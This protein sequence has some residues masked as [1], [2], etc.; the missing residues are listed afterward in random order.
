MKRLAC[1]LVTVGPHMKYFL[2]TL[3]MILGAACTTLAADVDAPAPD[4]ATLKALL[5]QQQQQI[6]QLRQT[7]QEQSRM[8]DALATRGSQPSGE[9]APAVSTLSRGVGEIASTAAILPPLP[10]VTTLAAP[11]PVPQAAAAEQ[12][13]PLQIHLGDATITPVGFMDI[14]NTWRSTN[15]GTSL[16]TNFGSFPYNNTVPGRLTEDKFSAENSRL[17]LRVDAKV[18]GANVLGYFEGDF[19][20]GSPSNNTQVSSNSFLFRIRQYY[21]D[22]RKGF[23]EVMA[24]QAWSMILPNRN[25]MGVLPADLFYT[26][27]VDVNYTNGLYWGRIPGI[28]FIGHPNKTVTFGIALENSTQ[29]FGGSGGGGTPT[30]PAAL[31]TTYNA[32]L[33]NSVNNDRT[34]PNVHPDIIGKLVIQ[35]SSRFHFE[36]GGVESTVKLFNPNTNTYFTKAGGAGTFAIHAELFKN[37]R[38]VTNNF[39]S[40]GAGRYLF[41]AVPNFIVR[42]DGSPSL[43]HSASTVTGFEATVKNIAPYIYYGGVYAGRNVALDTNGS[44]IGY[45]YV[46]S[47]NS[48][49]RSIKEITTGYTHTL[50]RDGKYGALQYMAQYAYFV[51]NPWYVAPNSPK[52]AHETAVWFNLRY[53]LPGSAPTIKY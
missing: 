47:P 22:V 20:G 49:N 11:L 51:R 8:L 12:P 24:G 25:G 19:V 45:G 1:R 16:Q 17:G 4:L 48:Q 3:V 15:A 39:Y 41:G 36:V 2:F 9:A 30:L 33:D 13:S 35:P 5:A 18:K 43:M 27:V 21:V 14:T 53:V 32:E 31:A 34:T 10:A 52:N 44:R 38:F 7:L 23:W 40:D 50:W 37:F 42:A 6:D 28:R 29:Y 26:Q 46:G